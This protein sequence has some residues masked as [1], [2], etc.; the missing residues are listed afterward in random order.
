MM[1]STHAIAI[2]LTACVL[3]ACTA[4]SDGS[5]GHEVASA[6]V[7]VSTPVRGTMA[8]TVVAY[9]TVSPGPIYQQTV[10]VAAD[11]ALSSIDV[12]QGEH[13]A[14]G[15]VLGHATLSASARVAA[16]QARTAVESASVSLARLRRLQADKLATDEQ[17]SQAE[18]AVTDARIVLA[19]LPTAGVDGAITLKAP[20]DGSVASISAAPGQL[21]PAGSALMTVT[22][23]SQRMLACGVEPTLVRA[24]H[25]GMP[26]VMTPVE[27]GD[28]T[29]GRVAAV[30]DA[31]DTQTRL[32]PVR[33]TPDG[34]TMAGSAWRA[35]ITIGEADGWLV[36][37]DAV[38]ED[39]GAHMVFQ[40]QHGKARRVP[41]VV[42]AE[43]GDRMALGGNVDPALPLIIAGAPQ[44]ADGMNVA[45]SE[46]R[47]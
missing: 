9:G 40:V 8:R 15:Q 42:L 1:R 37:A 18:K 7:T 3:A 30:G 17:V 27:G 14:R 43:R 47:K 4:P 10:S 22:P 2:V 26:V 23:T 41:V 29:A 21:V 19:S 5:T 36:P 38:V 34:D 25:A 12:A 35:E 6:A 13:V 33:V 31:I 24:I 32:V 39:G 11:S 16:G 46:D 44:V 45:T 28:A 20:V